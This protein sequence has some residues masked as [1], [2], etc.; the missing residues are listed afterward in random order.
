MK[1]SLKKY[2]VALDGKPMDTAKDLN[3]GQFLGNLLAA[4]ATPREKGS[5]IKMIDWALALYK[6]GEID[7][8]EADRIFLYGFV[9]D[10]E[11]QNLLAAQ[12]MK[13]IDAIK[14]P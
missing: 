7:I 14:A 4:V 10:C 9:Q 8:D 6:T 11:A 2:F 3:M 12:L 1:L 13:E 5:R